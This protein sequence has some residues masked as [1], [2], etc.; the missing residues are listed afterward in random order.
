MIEISQQTPPSEMP[1]H[2]GIIEKDSLRRAWVTPLCLTIL[3]AIVITLTAYSLVKG[4]EL[5]QARDIGARLAGNVL[6]YGTMLIGGVGTIATVIAS[7]SSWL[8]YRDRH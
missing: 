4:I 5:S 6:L 3:A 1:A 8:I 7:L 2:R